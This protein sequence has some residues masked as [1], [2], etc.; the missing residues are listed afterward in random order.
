[1]S[2][3]SGYL[4]NTQFHDNML[5]SKFSAFYLRKLSFLTLGTGVEEFLRQIVKFGYPICY[6]KKY[7]TPHFEILDKFH[8]PVLLLLML[9][10]LTFSLIPSQS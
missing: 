3:I 4:D 8:M 6:T 5:N 7:F 1:M 9:C 2:L 10:I